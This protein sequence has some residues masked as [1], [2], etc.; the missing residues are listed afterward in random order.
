VGNTVTVSGGANIT[1][2]SGSTY[3]RI[4]ISLPVASNFAMPMNAGARAE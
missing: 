1:Q 4:G 3:T 2:T